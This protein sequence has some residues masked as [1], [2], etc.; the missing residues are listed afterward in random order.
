MLTFSARKTFQ[1]EKMAGKSYKIQE[2]VR[3]N[4]TIEKIKQKK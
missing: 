3:K 2:S 1:V 4:F